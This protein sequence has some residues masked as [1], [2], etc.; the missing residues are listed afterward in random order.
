MRELLYLVNCVFHKLFRNLFYLV[1]L[2]CHGNAA[3]QSTN[4]FQGNIYTYGFVFI[5]IAFF[6]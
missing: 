3:E 6:M 2:I 1:K 4:S 5:F